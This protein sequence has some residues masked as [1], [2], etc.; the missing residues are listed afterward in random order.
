MTS[1]ALRLPEHLLDEAKAAAAEDKV[2]TNQ[3][4]VAFIAEG[5]GQRRG[6]RMMRDRAARADLPAALA[7][8]ERLAPDTPPEPG[9][10]LPPPVATR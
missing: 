5:I 3:L 6:L 9:D 4:L 7:M 10:D 1:F 2:S 8:L